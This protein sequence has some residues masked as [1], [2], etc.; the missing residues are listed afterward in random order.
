MPNIIPIIAKYLN[1][2]ETLV[3]HDVE[4]YFSFMSPSNYVSRESLFHNVF[5]PL[6]K[7]I[8][9]KEINLDQA[10]LIINKALN[11]TKDTYQDYLDEVVD[12]LKI[13]FKNII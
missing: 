7:I 11:L 2:D 1:I 5:I 10:N 3:Q 6:A 8:F 4:K 12:Q 13:N 9:K